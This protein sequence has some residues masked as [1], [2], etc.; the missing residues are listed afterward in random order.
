MYA[1]AAII[2]RTIKQRNERHSRVLVQAPSVK[3]STLFSGLPM[4][5]Q[6]FLPPKGPTAL[7]ALAIVLLTTGATMCNFAF[8]ASKYAPTNTE[9]H[10][11]LKSLAYVGPSVMGIGA[12]LIIVCCVLLFD[13]REKRIKENVKML[14]EQQQSLSHEFT[15]KAILA[16]NANG[17][18]VA[19]AQAV[20]TKVAKIIEAEAEAKAWSDDIE[21]A[22][23]INSEAAKTMPYE[24]LSNDS[25]NSIHTDLTSQTEQIKEQINNIQTIGSPPTPRIKMTEEPSK[26]SYSNES[27]GEKWF[28]LLRITA[29]YNDR[30]PVIKYDPAMNGVNGGF[31]HSDYDLKNHHQ[32]NEEDINNDASI[33]V[34]SFP[35]RK[36]GLTGSA[37]FSNNCQQRE[38][39]L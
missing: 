15:N 7:L 36:I 25:S 6:C 33:E 14:A 11:G 19:A 22:S 39:F 18:A 16:R 38:T 30:G 32:T 35:H 28:P 37:M 9:L 5:K 12:F 31:Q 10:Q 26:I 1:R 24:P 20:V 13:I 23:D 29:L 34:T 8:N 21:R 17:A 4:S 3:K 27:T 2:G